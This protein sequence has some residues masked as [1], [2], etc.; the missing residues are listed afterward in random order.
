M[1]KKDYKT[2]IEAYEEVASLEISPEEDRGGAEYYDHADDSEMEVSP[3]DSYDEEN[4]DLEGLEDEKIQMVET[5]LRSL[6]A[7]AHQAC[8][9]IKKGSVVEPWMQDLI[10]SA[11]EHIVKV[12]NT[13]VYRHD[14]D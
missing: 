12:A 9:A 3:T 10:T 4:V 5:R 13:L 1:D 11:E 2:L 6:V 7:H 8:D 14:R